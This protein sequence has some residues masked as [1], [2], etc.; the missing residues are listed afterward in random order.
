[1]AA[2]N[3]AKEYSNVLAQAYPYTL[4]FGD[5]YATPNNGRYR[6]TGSKTIEIPTI[7]TTGRVDSNRDTIAV[8]QRNYDNAW[9]PKVLTNQRK[10][11]TLVHPADINQT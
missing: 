11:S 3:Y 7:S 6:W 1:M 8:A 10:W 9:E 2:L 4:N 5:L